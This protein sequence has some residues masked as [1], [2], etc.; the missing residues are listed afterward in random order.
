MVKYALLSLLSKNPS[1]KSIFDF[2]ILIK[3]TT[4]YF[5]TWGKK[6]H[7]FQKLRRSCALYQ[8]I[9][10]DDN[11][12]LNFY[13]VKH[14]KQAFNWVWNQKLCVFLCLFERAKYFCLKP[15]QF[16]KA[17]SYSSHYKIMSGVLCQNQLKCDGFISSDH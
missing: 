5:Q 14:S 15:K 7:L 1:S 9:K 8:S 13:S 4:L 3:H 11:S 6:W 16:V 12:F 2:I 17:T 10:N